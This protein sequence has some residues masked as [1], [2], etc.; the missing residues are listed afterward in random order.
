MIVVYIALGLI[1]AAVLYVIVTYNALVSLRVRVNEGY[2]A[3][4]PP[5]RQR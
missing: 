1:A 5:L 2:R 4:D 3:G